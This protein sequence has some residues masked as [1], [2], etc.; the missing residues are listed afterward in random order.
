MFD[1]SRRC[2]AS[3]SIAVCC[4]L[5]SQ[6]LFLNLELGWWPQDSTGPPLFASH[7]A[8]VIDARVWLS[9][10]RSLCVHGRALPRGATPLAWTKNLRSAAFFLRTF[11][12]HALPP[13]EMSYWIRPQISGGNLSFKMQIIE[14]CIRISS[15]LFG[16]ADILIL[17]QIFLKEE[18]LPVTVIFLKKESLLEEV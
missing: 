9:E 4:N 10:L 2:W 13:W 17:S 18:K 11:T 12:Q 14:A 8:G 3:S 7:T 15:Q 5:L 1:P 16:L 6:G